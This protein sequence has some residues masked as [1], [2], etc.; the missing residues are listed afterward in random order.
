MSKA[1]VAVR[2]TGV[3]PGTSN[4]CCVPSFSPRIGDIVKFSEAAR[5]KEWGIKQADNGIHQIVGF[6]YV[7]EWGANCVE[8]ENGDVISHGWLILVCGIAELYE[9]HLKLDETV[10]QLQKE[11]NELKSL[12]TPVAPH[13]PKGKK[14]VRVVPKRKK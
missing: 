4:C 14:P 12:R 3:E 9:R 1:I 5:D 13:R 2:K 7:R 10:T 8:L 11:I 6:R